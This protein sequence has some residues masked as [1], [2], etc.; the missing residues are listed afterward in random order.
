M[1]WDGYMFDCL[2]FL[3]KN[4]RVAVYTQMRGRLV[5]LNHPRPC[6]YFHI[7]GGVWDDR[8]HTAIMSGE[9]FNIHSYERTTELTTQE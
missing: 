8:I 3:S 1:G 6:V 9:N 5:S 7:I 4:H 2:V